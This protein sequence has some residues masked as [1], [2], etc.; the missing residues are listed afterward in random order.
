M[1]EQVLYTDKVAGLSPVSPTILWFIS[2]KA[3]HYTVTVDAGER[4]PY[5][6]PFF[7]CNNLK[8]IYYSYMAT[9]KNKIVKVWGATT[10]KTS[11]AAK[12]QKITAARRRM[13]GVPSRAQRSDAG[14]KRK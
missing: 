7:S 14:K 2:L 8:I 5:E 6:P 12:E 3:E 9:T 13:F 4:Y 11:F 1:I 10:S